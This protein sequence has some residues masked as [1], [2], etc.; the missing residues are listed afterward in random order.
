M[1]IL[2]LAIALSS[3]CLDY[4]PVQYYSFPHY[5]DYIY[6]IIP[7]TISQSKKNYLPLLCFQNMKSVLVINLFIWPVFRL[8]FHHTVNNP[9]KPPCHAHK[10]LWLVLALFDLLLKILPEYRVPWLS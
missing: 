6:Y 1:K 4:S 7:A 3:D 8:G 10:R 5:K 9:H 2:I